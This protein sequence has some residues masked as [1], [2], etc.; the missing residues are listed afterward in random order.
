MITT[1][2]NTS[3]ICIRSIN[4]FMLLLYKNNNNN[5]NADNKNNNI[6]KNNIFVIVNRSLVSCNT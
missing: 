4:S 5:K 1:V 6:N 2:D 3:N